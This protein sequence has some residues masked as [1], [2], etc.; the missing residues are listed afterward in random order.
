MFQGNPRIRAWNDEVEVTKEIQYEF[1]RC[2]EDII[3]FSKKY[4][5]IITI[6]H[7]RILIGD[8]LR[9]YQKKMLK[10]FLHTPK[11]KKNCIV[12]APRQSAKTTTAA[13]YITHQMLFNEDK[14]IAILANKEKTAIEILERVKEIYEG[15]PLWMQVGVEK[16]G[17]NRKTIQLSNKI[18]VIAE[19]TS[20]SAIRGMSISLLYLDE[21]AFIPSHV[22]DEFMTSVYPTISS[23]KKSKIIVAS[24]PNG[25]NHFYD[26]WDRA[27]RGDNSFYPIQIRWNEPPNRDEEWRQSTIKDI[28]LIKFNQEFAC[29]H[30]DSVVDIIDDM[31][32]ENRTTLKDL[33]NRDKLGIKK[34][35]GYK[36]KT[37]YG[38]CNF[39]G[40]AKYK[41]QI[42][43]KVRT[44]DNIFVCNREHKLIVGGETVF[45]KNL[46]EGNFVTNSNL[47]QEVIL[48]ISKLNEKD[49]VY[50]ILSVENNDHSYISNNI[51]H[52]NCKFIGSTSTL[53]DPDILENLSYR[54]PISYKYEGLFQIWE[55][56]VDNCDY[57]IGVD[58]AEGIGS[59][60][61]V[62]QVLKINNSKDIVQV[63][64]YSNNFI[65]A[66]NFSKIVIA[67]SKYYNDAELM[68][69]NN[70]VGRIVANTVWN[71]Y[72]YGKVVNM[73][74]K[75]LGIRSTRKS[76]LDGNVNMKKYI[77]SNWLKINDRK[78]L[79]ELSL[80]KEVSPNVYKCG[81]SDHDDHVTALLWGLYYLI[82][83]FYSGYDDSIKD[84]DAKY[85]LVEPNE[86]VFVSDE[87][88]VGDYLDENFD[89]S[90]I[91]EDDDENFDSY[92]D[93]FDDEEDVF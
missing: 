31:G 6:D 11:N 68:I 13:I 82:T 50:D 54:D 37:P 93:E 43:Y 22:A 19:S 3:Y 87:E 21:F 75:E 40:I 41:K 74:S 71:D 17:W 39:Y 90:E 57:V 47:E 26:L 80:Y 27:V 24:T 91:Y 16:G 56:P 44:Y 28:G 7:G 92:L 14:T 89:D 9:E 18:K 35:N 32:N 2:M 8:K 72:D 81:K 67:I 46:E 78:T 76:K 60:F 20:S 23:G 77:E 64:K 48:E 85:N 38:Y 79:H 49:N 5:N 33:Y 61:S 88:D 73:N 4:C 62:V 86:P 52:S 65:D 59:D 45:L 51:I 69:E 36:I 84:I 29:L 53:I 1:L 25:I 10:A 42:L 66:Y 30:G 15:L 63:A 70:N 83:P 58:S 34:V 55:E 12:L